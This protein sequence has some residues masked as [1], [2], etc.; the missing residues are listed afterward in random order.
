METVMWISG[1]NKCFILLDFANHQQGFNSLDNQLT[2]PCI[3]W[4]FDL[5][6]INPCRQTR[7]IHMYAVITGTEF[8]IP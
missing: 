2:T 4:S 5:V 1:L 7:C 6:N 8:I 3:S